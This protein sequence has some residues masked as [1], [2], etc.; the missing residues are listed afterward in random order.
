MLTILKVKYPPH[1]TLPCSLSPCCPEKM[2]LTYMP[3]SLS[4]CYINIRFPMPPHFLCN[5]HINYV[6][7]RFNAQLCGCVLGTASWYWAGILPLGYQHSIGGECW[8]QLL[9]M[10]HIVY[11]NSTALCLCAG[12]SFLILSRN[13]SPRLT[14]QHCGWVLSTAPG[15]GA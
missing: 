9:G 1:L 2:P 4:P 6:T 11:G 7:F 10:E 12:H 8:A 3:C 15:Y 13:S 5:N 14:A